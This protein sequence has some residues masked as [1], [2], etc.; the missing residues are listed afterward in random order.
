MACREEAGKRGLLRLVRAPT[1]E[2][3]LDPTGRAPGRGAYLHASAD[4]VELARRRRAL[5]R[6]LKAPVHPSLWAE[7]ASALGGQ[8]TE[9]A[10]PS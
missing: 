1:G 4:C 8:S 9:P 7:M 5:E 3:R 10:G 6:A 2:V